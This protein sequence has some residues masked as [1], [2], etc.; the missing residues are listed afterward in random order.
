M[1]SFALRLAIEPS[2]LLGEISPLSGDVLNSYYG[3]NVT[4]SSQEP[5]DQ[6]HGFLA[7]RRVQESAGGTFYAFVAGLFEVVN[8]ISVTERDLL[9]KR[10]AELESR[11]RAIFERLAQR[12]G[13]NTVVLTTEE[14]WNDVRY[15]EIFEEL[16]SDRSTFSR[17][18]LLRDTLRW[19]SSEEAANATLPFIEALDGF[20]LTAKT[21]RLV[22]SWPA[23]LLYTP[24]EVAEARYLHDVCAV[25]VKIGHMEEQTYDRYIAPFMSIVHLRQ[26][27]CLRSS[28]LKPRT[29]TPY[30]DK[31]RRDP[32][33]RVFFAEGADEIR[34]KLA[35]HLTS[36]NHLY[37]IASGAGEILH[38]VVD[39]LVFA[40]ECVRATG[41]ALMVKDVQLHGGLDVINKVA[42]GD[43]RIDAL[44]AELPEILAA[45]V[46]G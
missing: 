25:N 17:G 38:P 5:I 26:P 46:T 24:L 22:G 31:A 43:L 29:V 42:R 7:A 33:I 13:V 45:H 8:C 16:I 20:P 36:D 19:Y 12:L 21:R 3:F 18:N 28:R 6:I 14:M 10:N 40:A 41:T 32:K 15:W 34:A 9:A 1:N 4:K 2:G 37:A 30:I 11:K 23:A 39:K 35:E 27:S 44:T